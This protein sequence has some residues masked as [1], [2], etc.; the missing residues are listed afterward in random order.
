MA[1]QCASLVERSAMSSV[2]IQVL[3]FDSG[4][5]PALDGGFN[6]LGFPEDDDPDVIYLEQAASGLVLEDADELE[7]YTSMFRCLADRALSTEDTVTFLSS[8]TKRP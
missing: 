5:H 4:A 3:P 6:I 1:E 8:I 7:R 2:A